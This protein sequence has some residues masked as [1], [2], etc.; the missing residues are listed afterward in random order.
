MIDK[1]TPY[2]M[3]GAVKD[4]SVTVMLGG[5][6][7]FVTTCRMMGLP[8]DRPTPTSVTLELT[9]TA[10][11]PDDDEENL[12]PLARSSIMAKAT[13]TDPTGLV[14]NFVDA[15]TD[16]LTVFNIRPA[17][18]EL[19]FP[20]VTVRPDVMFN[21]AISVT[22]PA[23]YEDEM[24]SGGLLFTFYGMGDVVATYDTIVDPIV[25]V[26]LEADGTLSPGGTYQVLA[27]EILA[28]ADWGEMFQGHVH[29]R[30]DYTNCSGLGWVTDFTKVNQA[31]SA[32]VIDA[33]TGTE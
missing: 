9:L 24:A 10:V 32:F 11:P 26:G 7:D 25:G 3:V 20:V 14:N 12:F 1:L 33:D 5:M 2:A 16:L 22:N 8:R 17:Q 15:F 30:A 21:T 29:L 19:L 28:A 13:F 27:S 4:G 23:Y 6:D 18:C 31:Y